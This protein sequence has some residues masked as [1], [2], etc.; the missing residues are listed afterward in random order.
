MKE[1]GKE[2]EQKFWDGHSFSDNC[3][4]TPHRPYNLIDKVYETFS[5]FRRDRRGII[6]LYELTKLIE[7]GQ[8]ATVQRLKYG[9]I[10]DPQRFTPGTFVRLSIDYQDNSRSVHGCGELKAHNLYGVVLKQALRGYDYDILVC[11][12]IQRAQK[13]TL[14]YGSNAAFY[15]SIKV[16]QVSHFRQSKASGFMGFQSL[17]RVSSMEILQYGTRLRENQSMPST[18]PSILPEGFNP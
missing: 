1:L 3:Q 5:D 4:W 13:G 17:E 14:E 9:E 11:Y 2:S 12:E 16:G 18:N 6:E 15:G 8:I 7:K 10:F